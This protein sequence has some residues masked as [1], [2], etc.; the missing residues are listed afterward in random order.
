MIDFED[1]MLGYPIQ[2]IAVTF[3]YGNDRKD[4]HD[5]CEAYREGYIT[6]RS[7]PVES[8]E[9]IDVLGAARAAMFI[10]YVARIDRDPGEFINRKCRWLEE[11]L[12][13]Y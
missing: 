4:Y 12:K 3:Y 2:D 5:L 1:I 10:N 7:W 6:I 8:Q 13:K 9:Q 11:F